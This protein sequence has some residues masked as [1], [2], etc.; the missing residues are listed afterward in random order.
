[1]TS[2]AELGGR[3]IRAGD[4]LRVAVGV[5]LALAERRTAAGLLLEGLRCNRGSHL[6]G[7]TG[8]SGGGREACPLEEGA[9][10]RYGVSCQLS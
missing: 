4:R 10:I 3:C 1:M 6:C 2:R 5:E 9:A 7:E 8:S